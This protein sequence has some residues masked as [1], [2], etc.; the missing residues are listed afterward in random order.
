MPLEQLRQFRTS[1]YNILGKAKDALFGLMDAALITRSIYAFVELA[2]S[3]V[4]RR[5]W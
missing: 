5:K 4:F 1:V 3:P 2:L